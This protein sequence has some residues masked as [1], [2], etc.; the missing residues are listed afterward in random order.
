MA[1]EMRHSTIVLS[2][3]EIRVYLSDW[4]GKPV[5]HIRKFMDTEK[6]T[7]P[8]KQG[9]M[10]PLDNL[11]ELAQSILY[12]YAEETGVKYEITEME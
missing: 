12:V 4:K 11:L 8:T 5:L 1:N 10:V 3:P 7:G 9:V 2:E 6:Y